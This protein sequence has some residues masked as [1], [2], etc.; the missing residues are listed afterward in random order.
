MIARS[1]GNGVREGFGPGVTV[2]RREQQLIRS[3][4]AG[5]AARRTAAAMLD[6]H[7]TAAGSLHGGDRHRAARVRV[8]CQYVHQDRRGGHHLGLL[9]DLIAVVHGRNRTHHAP[10]FQH[11]DHRRDARQRMPTPTGD[12]RGTAARQKSET[13]PQSHQPVEQHHLEMLHQSFV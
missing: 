5:T 4:A 13:F 12:D 10:G 11:F 3:R 8:V 1:I 2:G 9:L 6:R 7:R